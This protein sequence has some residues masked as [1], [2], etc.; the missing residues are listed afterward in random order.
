MPA[1]AVLLVQGVCHGPT[2]I[3]LTGATASLANLTGC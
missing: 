2:G 1:T 3:T